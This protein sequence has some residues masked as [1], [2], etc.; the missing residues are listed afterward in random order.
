MAHYYGGRCS[1]KISCL[2]IKFRERQNSVLAKVYSLLTYKERLIKL[3]LLPLMYHLELADI[4]FY[5]N[6][7]K[8]RSPRFNISDYVTPTT[9]YTRSSDNHSLNHT[10]SRTRHF[11]YHNRLPRLWNSLP[12]I[13][14]NLTS[15]TIK[16]TLKNL[17][18]QHFLCNFDSDAPCTFH[19]KCPCN[20]CSNIHI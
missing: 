6:S 3:N 20:K 12:P 13:D 15:S 8:N 9:G 2:R 17:L 4:M 1:S 16:A 10:Y 7:Y 19:L 14:M 5:V 11:Y 18:W